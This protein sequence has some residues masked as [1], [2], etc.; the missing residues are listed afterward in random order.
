VPGIPHRHTP[1]G[2]ALTGCARAW[3]VLML[4]LDLS[5]ARTALDRARKLL[6]GTAALRDAYARLKELEREERQRQRQMCVRSRKHRALAYSPTALRS[7][8]C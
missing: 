4:Q 8:T 2:V 1:P 7:A 6:G 5:G 3:Q